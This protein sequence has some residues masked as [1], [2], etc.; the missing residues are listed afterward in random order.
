MLRIISFAQDNPKTYLAG[1]L[2]FGT[3][4]RLAMCHGNLDLFMDPLYP[5]IH[6]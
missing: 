4:L 2:A 6:R 3:L 5:L 1:C